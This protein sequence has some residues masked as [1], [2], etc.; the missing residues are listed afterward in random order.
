MSDASGNILATSELIDFSTLQP[1]AWNIIP[2]HN[3]ALTNTQ[4]EFYV[5]LE[6]FAHGNYLAAQVETPLR[7]STFFYLQNGTYVPQT[8]GRFMIGAVVDT[9]FVRLS[10]MQHHCFPFR[11]DFCNLPTLGM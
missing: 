7:D 2:I 10:P 4:G 3:F 5:G 1:Q 9:P 8:S 11:I 6:M